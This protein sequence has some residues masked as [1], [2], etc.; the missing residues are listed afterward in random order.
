MLAGVPAVLAQSGDAEHQ[1]TVKLC[2]AVGGGKYKPEQAP[3]TDFY[4]DGQ[5]GHGTHDG[6]IV[7][8]SWSRTR[9]LATRRP[10]PAGTGHEQGQAILNADCATPEPAPGPE[11]GPEPERKIRICHATS[12]TN[13]SIRLE[14]TGDREQR[15]S[16]GRTP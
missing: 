1:D 7:P 9:D 14:R 16:D 2:H 4:G 10:S 15:R 3:E 13:E 12:S 5:Q 11:P 6:D 8:R